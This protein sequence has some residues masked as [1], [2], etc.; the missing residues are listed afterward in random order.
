LKTFTIKT[1]ATAAIA[2]LLTGCGGGSGTGLSGT[3]LSAAPPVTQGSLSAKLTLA[4]GTVFNQADNTTGLNVVSALRGPNGNTVILANTPSITGPAG[5]TVPAGFLGA[6]DGQNGPTNVDDGTSTLSSSPQVNPVATPVDST[7]GTF[8]GV[9]SAGLAPLNSDNS[10][11]GQYYP[12]FPN[13][14]TGNGF[15]AS[16]YGGGAF[17]PQ[18]FGSAH[19]QFFLVG[20]PAVP[21]FKD[22]TSAAPA[23]AGY[24]P[25]FTAFNIPPVA[26]TYTMNV[27]V[28]PSNATAVSFNATAALTTT[29][30]PLTPAPSISNVT[31]DGAGGLTGTV[32]IPNNAVETLVFVRNRSKGLFFTV[33]VTGTGATTF[34][35]PDFLGSCAGIGCQNSPATQKPSLNSP[36]G[37]NPGDTYRIFAV[38]FDYN[39]LE[40]EP[41]TNTQQVPTFVGANGQADI[42]IGLPFNAVY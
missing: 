29:T 25:G 26:G 35:L 42:S 38:S 9:F 7:F 5:F 4:V 28:S 41:P 22:G 39:A 33:E 37:M 40:A 8:T 10:G 16:N 12:G 1:L 32:T 24:M 31:E 21:F 27:A 34:T 2:A 30:S 11:N 23:F 13:A 15:G 3:G 36:A 20:P 6:Y 14:T 19:Q 18:P 17:W